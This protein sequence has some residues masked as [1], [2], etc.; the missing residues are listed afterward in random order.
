MRFG[1]EQILGCG[2]VTQLSV[3]VVIA[4]LIPVLLGIWLDRQLHSPFPVITLILMVL[5]ITIGTVAVYRN[6]ASVY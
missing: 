2:L 5:G 6:V 4:V 1:R 3:T